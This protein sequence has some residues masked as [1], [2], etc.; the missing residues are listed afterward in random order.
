MSVRRVIAVFGVVVALLAGC[1][2][3]RDES[4]PEPVRP[5]W[6]AS[7]LPVPPGSAGRLVVRDATACA[8]RWYVVGAVGGPDGAT[9][10]AAWGSADGRTWASLPLRPISYYGER[11]ILYAVGCHE[12]RV[13]VVGARAG[14]AHGNPRVRTWRQ[15]ADGGLTE[16]P[17]EF[18]V[19]GGPEAVSASRIAGGARGWL[20]AGARTGGAA[21]WRSPDAADFQLVDGA[22]GLASDAGLTTL[23]TDALAMPD[24]WLV[25]GGGRPADRA[26]RDPFV[27]FSADGRSWTRLAL[28]ATGE[29]EIVQRLVRVGSSVYAVGVRGSGFQAWVAEP[30][31][32]ATSAGTWRAVGRFGATGT[33][34]VAGVEAAAGGG[35]GVLA[36][37]VAAGGHRLWRSAAGGSSWVPV[38]LPVDVFAGGDTSA[39]VAVWDGRMVVTVDD[40]VAAR[41][42]FAPS[43]AV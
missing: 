36:M 15:D 40:G 18:E 41:V 3:G 27:W 7:H 13:A 43:A 12:G 34:A 26:D 8:G 6:E 9:R 24:G 21:V 29:D 37:T 4:P 25:G 20:I 38:A 1:R 30:A 16:V 28:P 19:Y 2:A 17:A 11:A 31:G 39:A 32:A 42:W 33:G 14:G 22:V 10:P 35:A 5:R 23:A